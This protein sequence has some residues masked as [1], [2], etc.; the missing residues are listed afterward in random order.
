TFVTITTITYWPPSDGRCL[1]NN[2]IHLSLS[3]N[4]MRKRRQR[5]G[6][7]RLPT[8]WWRQPA[9]IAG[10]LAVMVL[11]SALGAQRPQD[12]TVSVLYAGSLAT[13]MENGIGPAFAKATGYSY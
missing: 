10:V 4:L 8:V 12:R 7:L 3:L 13:V 2:M 6:V 1:D 11:S 5:A 9:R